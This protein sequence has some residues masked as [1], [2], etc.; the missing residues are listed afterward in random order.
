LEVTSLENP[1]T[2]TS[3]TSSEIPS[4]VGAKA[5]GDLEV[6]K[7]CDDFNSTVTEGSMVAIRERYNISKEDELHAPLLKQRPYNPGLL[8]MMDLARLHGMLKVLT[9]QPGSTTRAIVSSLEVQ[10]VPAEAALR[11]A[12]AP[13]LKRPSEGLMP[14]PEGSS[15]A[16]K[17]VKV[18]VGKHKSRCGDGSSQAHS[19]CKEPTALGGEPAQPT[20]CH[21]KS[22]RE[23]FKMI[24]HKNDVGYYALQMTDL[25]PW[26]PNLEM[27]A[28]WKAL[29][30]SV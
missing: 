20:Y 3:D 15:R 1:K 16:H 12:T 29:K 9:G 22:M 6:M 11:S 5:L 2:S 18:T 21:P 30:N 28:R 19:K 23:L 8:D 14:P 25:R 27:Q 17:R 13:T 26:D 10:E 7:V 4:S 24:V